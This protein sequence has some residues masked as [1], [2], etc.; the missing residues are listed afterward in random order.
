MECRTWRNAGWLV[1]SAEIDDLNWRSEAARQPLL[2][3]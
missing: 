1:H 2:T 3:G